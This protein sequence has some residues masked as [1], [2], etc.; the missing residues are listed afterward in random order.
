MKSYRVEPTDKA[1]VDAGEV[2]FWINDQSETAALRWYEGLMKA[3]RSLEK[4]PYRCPLTPESVFFKEEIR[5][6]LYG[7]YRILFTIEEERVLILRVRHGAQE[8]LK[9]EDDEEKTEE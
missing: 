6:L 5:Q 3:F 9:P 2:Y 1:L 4:N 7:K 8:Y